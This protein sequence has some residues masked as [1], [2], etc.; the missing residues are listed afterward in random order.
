MSNLDA[1]KFSFEENKLLKRLRRVVGQTISD[2]QMIENGDMVMVCVS[3]GKDSFVLLDILLKLKAI[4][5]IHFDIIAV[6][7]DQ[8]Q[9]GFPQEVL[10]AYFKENQ[11]NFKVIEEDTHS[12]VERI[13]PQGKTRCSLCSRLR[14]GILYRVAKE[15][16]ATKIAL[17][18]HQ[19]DILET[20]FLNLFYAG[21]LK[22]MP[23]KLLSDDR[24]N[25]VIRPMAYAL[26]SDIEK[27][28]KVKKFP[29]IPCTQCGSQPNL[30]RSQM[31]SMIRAWRKTNPGRVE[32]IFRSLQ[33]VAPSHLLDLQL[34]D[35]NSLDISDSLINPVENQSDEPIQTLKKRSIMMKIEEN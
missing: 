31:K 34:F 33:S 32:N 2:Y 20:F 6:N 14:R 3:G 22:A 26:E 29:I 24:Q 9:P 25:I 8:K 16:G 17:G 28:S 23:P 7:V 5:P 12:I 15:I 18:H 35:F 27:W 10:P 13:L 1:G 11:I 30:Q 21:K 4:S 19:D